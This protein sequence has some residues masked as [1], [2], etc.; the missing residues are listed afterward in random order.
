MCVRGDRPRF[1]VSESARLALLNQF[2][3]AV[4]ARDQDALL[5]LF[6]ED[7]TWTSDSGGQVVRGAERLTRFVTTWR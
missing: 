6:A 7:A 5:A 1:A 3:A 2:V 4:N